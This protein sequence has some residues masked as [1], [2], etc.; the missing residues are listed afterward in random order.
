ML[1]Y[2]VYGLLWM[3]LSISEPLCWRLQVIVN[4][5]LDVELADVWMAGIRWQYMLVWAPKWPWELVL[6]AQNYWSTDCL[7]DN[8]TILINKYIN[9]LIANYPQIL[10][11]RSDCVLLQLTKLGKLYSRIAWQILWIWVCWM[12]LLKKN[13]CLKWIPARFHS[14][15]VYMIPPLQN[16]PGIMMDSL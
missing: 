10:Q 15:L 2:C 7:L 12:P 6:R 4:G 1:F 5:W 9:I 3:F 11:I 14:H 16:S 8:I 13:A